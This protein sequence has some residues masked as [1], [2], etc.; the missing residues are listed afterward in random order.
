MTLITMGESLAVVRSTAPGG[1]AS[2]GDG[3][4]G[5]GGA[6]SN[7][8]IAAA[9]I[10]VAARWVGRVGSD[11]MGARIL[12][13][14]RAE[15]VEVRAEVMSAA[16]TGLLVKNQPRPGRSEVTYYRS[17]SAGSQLSS[18]DVDRL[19]LVAGDTLHLTG[20]TPAL[21]T[22]AAEAVFDAVARARRAGARVSFDVNHRS[23][24]WSAADAR[25]AY[26]KM[27]AAAD[28]VFAGDDEARLVLDLDEDA[29]PRV[30]AER[31]VEIGAGAAVIKLGDRGA[32]ALVDDQWI[33]ADAVRVDVVDTVGAGDAFVAAY[34]AGEILRLDSRACL[35][36]AV[37]NGA[38]ACTHPGDWEG[39]ATLAELTS[40][41]TDPVAR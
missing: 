1:F 38:A 22:T 21:S 11:A 8:A 4:V 5:V 39:S 10:G 6:E 19:G 12:R 3:N 26:W 27:I 32:G 15:G 37:R 20:I 34:L 28:I 13:E 16:P 33:R 31:L 30:L 29:D 40:E 17:G 9:R 25:A 35:D 23:R 24:L 18:S 36:L 41:A 7:V 2:T 14:L